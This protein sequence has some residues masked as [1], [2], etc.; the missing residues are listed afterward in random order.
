MRLTELVEELF[1]RGVESEDADPNPP[2]RVFVWEADGTPREHELE[3]VIVSKGRVM[4]HCT[5]KP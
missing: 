4:L 3:L 2:V 5:R 1:N